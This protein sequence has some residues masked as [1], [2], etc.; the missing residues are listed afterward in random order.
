MRHQDLP[1]FQ[2]ALLFW[3]PGSG[4]IIKLQKKKL[5]CVGQKVS[6]G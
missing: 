3:W 6:E 5:L 2:F 1:P 4:A